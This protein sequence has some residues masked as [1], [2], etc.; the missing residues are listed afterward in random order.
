MD[1]TVLEAA[2][3]GAFPVVANKSFVGILPDISLLGESTPESLTF[4]IQKIGGLSA[5]EK[6]GYRNE[7]RLNVERDHSL[8]KLAK[9]LVLQFSV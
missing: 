7:M 3:C 8:K 5:D 2:A 4:R 1:K 6:Q 9:E